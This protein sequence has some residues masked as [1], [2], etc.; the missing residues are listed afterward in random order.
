MGQ[1][2]TKGDGT[3]EESGSTKLSDSKKRGRPQSPAQQRAAERRQKEKQLNAAASTAR[4]LAKNDIAAWDVQTVAAKAAQLKHLDS[5]L[6]SSRN[7]DGAKLVRMNSGELMSLGLSRAAAHTLHVDLACLPDSNTT[8]T[9]TTTTNDNTTS[10]TT[11]TNT[12]TS[13]RTSSMGQKTAERA[14]PPPPR[15][16]PRIVLNDKDREREERR[17]E[18]E[19]RMQL[20]RNGEFQKAEEVDIALK[21]K[22]EEMAEESRRVEELADIKAREDR[23]LMKENENLKA[24][25]EAM[26]KQREEDRERQKNAPPLVD[27]Q[28]LAEKIRAMLLS[29]MEAQSKSLLEQHTEELRMSLLSKV[30]FEAVQAIEQQTLEEEAEAISNE[31]D[32]KN[33]KSSKSK[34]T[35]SG[36][37]RS[38]S[39]GGSRKK[40]S[41][42]RRNKRVK[43]SRPDEDDDYDDDVSIA[44]SDFRSSWRDDEAYDDE[45]RYIEDND[46]IDGNEDSVGGRGN[47]AD[48]PFKTQ[49]KS[50]RKQKTKTTHKNKNIMSTT[51]PSGAPSPL[52]APAGFG[53]RKSN[54]TTKADRRSGRSTRMLSPLGSTEERQQQQQQQQGDNSEHEDPTVSDKEE[55][56]VEEEE[57]PLP[58]LDEMDAS[59]AKLLR[60]SYDLI[61]GGNDSTTTAKAGEGYLQ[62]LH[63][64]GGVWRKGEGGGEGEEGEGEGTKDD[65]EELHLHG[66]AGVVGTKKKRKKKRRKKKQSSNGT[67][68]KEGD[69]EE[70]KHSIT[71]TTTSAIGGMENPEDLE[72]MKIPPAE[73][74][75]SSIDGGVTLSSSMASG[76]ETSAMMTNTSHRAT[77]VHGFLP[78]GTVEHKVATLE[79]GQK[80][81]VPDEFLPG[82]ILRN[83]PTVKLGKREWEN[84]VARNILVLY[85]ANMDAIRK[86]DAEKISAQNLDTTIETSD[87]DPG[88]D[89][90]NS[91]PKRRSSGKKT[92]NKLP[93]IKKGGKTENPSNQP[94]RM[95]KISMNLGPGKAVKQNSPHQIWYAGSGN[96]RAVWDGLVVADEEEAEKAM[97]KLTSDFKLTGELETL[98]KQGKYFKYIALVEAIL[99]ARAR[100]YERTENHWR[101]WRQLAVTANVFGLKL[102]DEKRFSQAM[103]MLK[104]ATRLMEMETSG[105]GGEEAQSASQTTLSPEHRM[106][107]KAFIQDSF[108]YYYYRRSKSAA[109]LQYAQKAMRIHVRLRA[110]EHVAKCHLHVGA[111]LARLRRH[112]EAIR[113]MG[114]SFLLLFSFVFSV[115][116]CI[117]L[118]ALAV[119]L[120]SFYFVYFA[121]VL[122]FLS[123]LCSF[124]SYRFYL[125]FDT[126][127]QAKSS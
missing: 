29:D 66:K 12:N 32:V 105:G 76:G 19:K 9:T 8:T 100:I 96:V 83:D 7:I 113:A 74:L 116:V 34:T 39:R 71:S 123:I 80:A 111:I 46:D 78:D 18:H 5:T 4:D 6:F 11:A 26:K 30:K 56:L 88:N 82:P 58:S 57:L 84:E 27:E 14:P 28:S 120:L 2:P 119:V 98:E 110:W 97:R 99:T 49:P 60:Q 35:K 24:E 118:Y 47:R 64:M 53:Q 87:S 112:D 104:N 121:L 125:P 55:E 75:S 70:N 68:T 20:A 69:V 101:L 77:A 122:F 33:R 108:S 89:S 31:G 13:T 79:P 72:E 92:G 22:E 85:K 109:A 93:P 45:R 62:E 51:H 42:K 40:S 114:M 43:K 48:Q 81:Q 65:V 50:R 124:L 15:P 23:R 41:G 106:E 63:K 103:Q 21:I 10:S 95:M 102:I 73:I 127:V 67:T 90:V 44:S 107:L 16:P 61:S 126:Y 86:A 25:L 59:T 91:S 115:S 1:K 17:L 54:R 36:K 38:K 117:H 37:R 52:E 3:T 94:S